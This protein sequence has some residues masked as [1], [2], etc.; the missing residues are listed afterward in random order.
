MRDEF[1]SGHGGFQAHVTAA[2]GRPA[3]PG[4]TNQRGKVWAG[5]IQIRI[6]VETKNESDH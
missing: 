3:P 6:V 1:S 2:T 5:V 4:N